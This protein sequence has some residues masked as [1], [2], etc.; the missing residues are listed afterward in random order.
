[1]LTCGFDDSLNGDRKYNAEQMSEL[2]EGIITDG[3]LPMI[4][5]RFQVVA[6]GGLGIAVR[7]GRC[8]FDNSWTNND[9][10]IPYWHETP[11]PLLPRIDSVVLETNR[12][13]EVRNNRI[14]ILKG[15]PSANPTP[16]ALLKSEYVNW[17][18]LS[19]V[20]LL[21]G[22][23]EITQENIINQV[24]SVLTPYAT[25]GLGTIRPQPIT[26]LQ[27]LWTESTY[28][29]NFAFQLAMGLDGVEE[30][31]LVDVAFDVPSVVLGMNAGVASAGLT[32]HNYLVFFAQ[33]VPA[34]NMT[35]MY[36]LYKA[37]TT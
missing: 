32:G 21:P 7:S 16:P 31:D 8:W 24:G 3:V 23:T 17:W 11:D 9:A 12:T 4:G 26:L 22:A 27:G 36:V 14:F 13:L 19:N 1:M 18:S 30:P 10:P 25:T 5:N 6:N 33:K 37:V 2:F 29:P 20:W 15:E 35:G 28:N 34:G